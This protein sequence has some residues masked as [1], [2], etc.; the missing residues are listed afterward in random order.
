MEEV[1]DDDDDSREQDCGAE[2]A[3]RNVASRL[4]GD[5]DYP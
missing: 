4:V 2:L 3:Q 5:E 1:L